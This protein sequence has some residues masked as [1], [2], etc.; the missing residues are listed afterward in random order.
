[1]GLFASVPEASSE[2]VAKEVPLHKDLSPPSLHDTADQQDSEEALDKIEEDPDALQEW[3]EE[4]LVEDG[5]EEKDPSE[6]EGEEL[7]EEFQQFS[8][9]LERGMHF[10]KETPRAM[11]IRRY[12]GE[13]LTKAMIAAR[14]DLYEEEF[15]KL[16]KKDK[17]LQRA[18]DMGVEDANMLVHQKLWANNEMG[19]LLLKA[20][21]RLKLD[22]PVLE[23][24]SGNTLKV[25][26]SK[27]DKATKK[28]LAQTLGVKM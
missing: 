18:Y 9:V 20:R 6:E 5:D 1:E 21:M 7:E 19:V 15:E 13:G 11:S 22:D 28:T 10:N 14:Y 26:L 25:I 27:A 24:L 2:S 16:L 3:T 17:E 4:A 12:A 23:Q 8:Y